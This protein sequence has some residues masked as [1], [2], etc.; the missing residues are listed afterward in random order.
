MKTNARGTK[1]VTFQDDVIF[2]LEPSVEVDDNL[3]IHRKSSLSS[4]SDSSLSWKVGDILMSTTLL[5]EKRTKVDHIPRRKNP[6]RGRGVPKLNLL[7][8]KDESTLAASI[9][10]NDNHCE[11]IDTS[12]MMTG[13]VP[14]SVAKNSTTSSFEGFEILYP[15]RTIVEYQSNTIQAAPKPST[16]AS[17]KFSSEGICWSANNC[18]GIDLVSAASTLRCWL[19]FIPAFLGATGGTEQ[20]IINSTHLVYTGGENWHVRLGETTSPISVDDQSPFSIIDQSDV[21]TS[22][23]QDEAVSD[24]SSI[25]LEKVASNNFPAF[26]HNSF[27]VGYE[28]ELMYQPS[29]TTYPTNQRSLEL[30]H[31]MKSQLFRKKKPMNLKLYSVNKLVLDT[32]DPRKCDEDSTGSPSGVDCFLSSIVQDNSVAPTYVLLA[33]GVRTLEEK[34]K[35]LHQQNTNESSVD[36]TSIDSESLYSVNLLRIPYDDSSLVESVEL[37]PLGDVID[38]PPSRWSSFKCFDIFD[39]VDRIDDC[40][41][42]DGHIL[43]TSNS[44]DESDVVVS[45]EEAEYRKL[46]CRKLKQ[47]RRKERIMRKIKNQEINTIRD[48][49]FS[50]VYR[51]PD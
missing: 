2:S 12:Q 21:A 11:N 1:R 27:D 42:D 14:L 28:V 46:L 19:L 25:F 24:V 4:Q 26:I 35:F 37:E 38:S 6:F 34:L 7:P 29:V 18:K 17:A 15:L 31:K 51:L 47:K 48:D 5:K 50:I 40:C 10:E 33:P 39:L 23:A 22:R 49:S 43:E 3:L 32:T 8:K 13:I 44:F 41:M 16:D 9:D 30:I 20:P 36:Q 45:A